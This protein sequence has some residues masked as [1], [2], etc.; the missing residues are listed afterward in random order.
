M[1]INKCVCL[2]R[3]FHSRGISLETKEM[4]GVPRGTVSSIYWTCGER[5]KYEVKEMSPASSQGKAGQGERSGELR[6][7]SDWR[8]FHMRFPAHPPKLTALVQEG[9]RYFPM[10][11]SGRTAGRMLP[12]LMLSPSLLPAKLQGPQ[13]QR[14]AISGTSPGSM[15]RRPTPSLQGLHKLCVLSNTLLHHHHTPSFCL[16]WLLAKVWLPEVYFR[17]GATRG[18]GSLWGWYVTPYICNSLLGH[19][20]FIAN[21]K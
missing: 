19:S 15:A 9:K 4:L 18:K 14:R 20:F 8:G 1:C 16:F 10:M 7:T 11:F 2:F 17:P 21:V 13:L 3:S 12:K 6:G 5:V